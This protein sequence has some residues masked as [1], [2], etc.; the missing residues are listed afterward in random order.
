MA[1]DNPKIFAISTAPSTSIFPPINN[2]IIQPITHKNAFRIDMISATSL[3]LSGT[4]LLCLS[5]Y[6]IYRAAVPNSTIPS[7]R[8][9]VLDRALSR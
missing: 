1:S 2:T 7:I 6:R 8:Q 9:I 3:L 5:E 4:K